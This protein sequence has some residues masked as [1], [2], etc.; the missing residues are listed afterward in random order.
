LEK[1]TFSEITFDKSQILKK[2]GP[3]VHPNDVLCSDTLRDTV[4]FYAQFELAPTFKEVC[5]ERYLNASLVEDY[6]RSMD[7]KGDHSE[8]A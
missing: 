6:I 5:G 2:N 4:S 7:V 8:G 1:Q 3:L